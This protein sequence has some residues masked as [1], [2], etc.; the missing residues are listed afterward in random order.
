MNEKTIAYYN[1]NALEY[2]NSVNLADMND[3]CERFLMYLKPGASIIDIGC[4]SGRD[5]KYFKEHGYYA[6]GLDASEN[7][8]ELAN[9]YSDCKVT[10]ADL[11][12]WQ[13][14]K[15]FD[16]FWANASLLHL[17]KE[18]IIIFFEEKN[19]FLANQGIIYFSMKSGI[20]TGNDDKGRFFTPFTEELLAEILHNPSLKLLERWSNPDSMGRTDIKW[21]TIIMRKTT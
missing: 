2:F 13:P 18:E 8:C 15:Q 20:P 9:Q 5:L 11:L 17:T 1:N 12:S 7:L 6:E 4:G 16:A 10:C 21:E 3:N 14:E 19:R